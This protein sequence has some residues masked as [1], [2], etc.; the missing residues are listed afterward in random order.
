MYL[1]EVVLS[2][3]PVLVQALVALN[4]GVYFNS[5]SSEFLLSQIITYYLFTI[6]IT[7]F[8]RGNLL[9]EFEAEIAVG[10]VA[11]YLIRPINFIYFKLFKEFSS[12]IYTSLTN[13]F[14]LLIIS[15]I[16]FTIPF[17]SFDLLLRA[18]I[19]LPITLINYFLILAIFMYL[20]LIF[21]KISDLYRI[22]G[23]SAFFIGGG[24]IQTS[25]F[26]DF[27]NYLPQQFLY[28]RPIEF[29]LNGQLKNFEI[30]VFYF[31]LWIVLIILLNKY[32][33]KRLETNGG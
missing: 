24:V 13:F 15:I 18:V 5:I 4:I 3:L 16:F 10:G 20:C 12:K 11:N 25:Y 32:T 1:H 22:F 8:Q 29:I 33:M 30:G 2:N 7:T 26:P 27:F 23:M 19:I 9:R 28:G 31:V 21:E 6:I 14:L 17:F